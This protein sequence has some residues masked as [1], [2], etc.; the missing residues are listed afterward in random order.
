MKDKFNI[1]PEDISTSDVT[2]AKTLEELFEQTS[3]LRD[4][5]N[6]IERLMMQI[7]DKIESGA[8]IF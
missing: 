4:R 5:V 7:L 6:S 8:P 2:N 3:D 1:K